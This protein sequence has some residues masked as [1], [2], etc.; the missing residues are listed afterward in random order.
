[1]PV[2]SKTAPRV[3]V[4]EADQTLQAFLHQA[5]RE[6]GYGTL[7]ASSVQEA[8]LFV[9]RQP[10]ELILLDLFAQST[11]V[12]FGL[13]R[14]LRELSYHLPL[15]VLTD[16]PSISEQDAQQQGCTTLLRRPFGLEDLLTTLAACLNQPWSPDQ[17]QQ[18]A[19]PDRFVSALARGDVEAALTACGD[20]VR[21]HPWLIP[22]YPVMRSVTGRAALRSL[23]EEMLAFFCDL[24][25]E[26]VHL[27]PSPSSIAAR[28]LVQWRAADGTF[29]QQMVCW[30]VR[31][32]GEQIS[33]V[34]MPH[35]HDEQ[36]AVLLGS[37]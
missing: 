11:Q 30:R 18:A 8:L 6:E 12:A 26:V 5:L 9:H 37:L 36:L 27:Y 2:P 34:G 14:P 31:F 23:L 22:A 4:V 21:C 32:S 3:V 7:G 35:A 29:Q 28:L 16:M 15:V 10:C 17:R 13:L 33:Q 24:G 20:E 25:L 19:V 1:M